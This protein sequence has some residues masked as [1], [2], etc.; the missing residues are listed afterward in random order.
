VVADWRDEVVDR[1]ANDAVSAAL[2][3]DSA[4]DVPR[5]LPV[6]QAWHDTAHELLGRFLRRDGAGPRGPV[7]AATERG[8]GGRERKVRPRRWADGVNERLY[9]VHMGWHASSPEADVVEMHLSAFRF[10]EGRHLLLTA[11]ALLGLGRRRDDFAPIFAD[12]L[13]RV[14]DHANPA[15][16][17]VAALHR[18]APPDTA[19]DVAL[20]R[21]AQVSADQSRQALRGYEWVTVCPEELVVRLGGADALRAT[22]AFAEVMPLAAGGA[23]LRASASPAQY[24]PQQALTVFRALAPVLPKG[25]PQVCP[26]YDLSQVVA[27]DAGEASAVTAPSMLGGGAPAYGDREAALSAFVVE[28]MTNGWI[29]PDDGSDAPGVTYDIAPGH[30][31]TRLTEQGQRRLDEILHWFA[32]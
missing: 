16:G 17:E 4:D 31:T 28:A 1:S 18:H 22:G 15:Y 11:S 20:L 14:G 19:L 29:L 25:L 8:A 32:D 27:A 26:G 24:G 12:L 6:V 9:S 2:Y 23:L 13:R 7:V 30:S 21:I 5:V 10:G 3:L